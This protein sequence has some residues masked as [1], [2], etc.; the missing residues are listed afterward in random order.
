M[1][2]GFEADGSVVIEWQEGCAV[3]VGTLA[4]LADPL[5]AL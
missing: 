5:V 4:E 3:D 2:A 1:K